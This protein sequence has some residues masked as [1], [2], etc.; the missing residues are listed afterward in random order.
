M[1]NYGPKFIV[2]FSVI[3][4]TEC[5]VA[6]VAIKSTRK[7]FLLNIMKMYIQMI[8]FEQYLPAEHVTKHFHL[9]K[10]KSG[11]NI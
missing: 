4:N 7:E 10:K 5:C 11:Q 6:T 9:F 1:S 8:L 3:G 2:T